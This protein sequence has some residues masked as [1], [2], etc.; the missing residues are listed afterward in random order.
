MFTKHFA[1][2]RNSPLSYGPMLKSLR[3]EVHKEG[4]S[5]PRQSFDELEPEE[6]IM[7]ALEVYEGVQRDLSTPDRKADFDA[8]M[9]G[10]HSSSVHNFIAHL[11]ARNCWDTFALCDPQQFKGNFSPEWIDQ[12]L[13]SC[14]SWSEW[15]VSD[16]HRSISASFKSD[17]TETSVVTL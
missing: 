4:F 3:A 5:M 15:R 7:I 14:I 16:D 11:L 6:K 8:A 17:S 10:R 9:E 13:R 1:Y 12:Y 2:T